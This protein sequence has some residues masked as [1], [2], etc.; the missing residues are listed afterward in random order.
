MGNIKYEEGQVCYLAPTASV[1]VVEGNAQGIFELT[2]DGRDFADFFPKTVEK[3]RRMCFQKKVNIGETILFN[4][5]STKV[6]IMVTS[7]SVLD[8]YA[9]D[10]STV[11][12]ALESCLKDIKK[13]FTDNLDFCSGFLNKSEWKDVSSL[14]KTYFP[15]RW[16]VYKGEK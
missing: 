9:D 8:K 2:A 11:S 16:T 5:G 4:E 14:L 6:V 3:F 1:L 7:Y 12:F 13:N 10:P 15:D